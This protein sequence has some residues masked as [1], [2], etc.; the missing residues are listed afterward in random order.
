MKD[1]T[2]AKLASAGMEFYAH[3]KKEA[4]EGEEFEKVFILSFIN[5]TWMIHLKYTHRTTWHFVN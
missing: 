2:I 1:G 5:V 3:A 4:G